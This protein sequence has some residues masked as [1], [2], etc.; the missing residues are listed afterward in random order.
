MDIWGTIKQSLGSVVPLLANAIVPGS[1]GVVGSLIASVLGI[2]NTPDAIATA[3]SNLTP[4]QITALKTAEMAHQEKLLEIGNA[5]DQMYLLDVQD[6][7]KREVELTKATGKS[8][9]NLYILAWT[10]VISFFIT[11][12]ILFFVPLPQG[13]ANIVYM[14][15]GTLGTGF[16]TVLGYFFGSSKGSSDKTA[17]LTQTKK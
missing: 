5:N 12:G 15:L 2:Q 10:V 17:L 4:E 14:L 16:A 1:G 11:V 3:V 7:R 6:A 9:L 13:Q 8:D